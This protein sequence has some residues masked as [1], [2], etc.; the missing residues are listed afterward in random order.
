MTSISTSRRT[1]SRL[2]VTSVASGKSWPLRESSALGCSSGSPCI[3]AHTG[4]TTSGTVPARPCPRQVSA[5]VSMIADDASM[6]VLA[7]C[8]PMSEATAS[9]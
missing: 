7:A 5:M 8:T 4:S 3:D 1:S 6:P 2:G 9:I